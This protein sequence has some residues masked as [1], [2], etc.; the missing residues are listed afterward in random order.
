MLLLLLVVYVQ[1][2]EKIVISATGIAFKTPIPTWFP[3]FI[4]SWALPWGRIKKAEIRWLRGAPQP[5][6]FLVDGVLSRKILL[7]AWVREGEKKPIEKPSLGDIFRYQ[8]MPRA[9]SSEE[10]KTRVEASPLIQALHAHQVPVDYSVKTGTGMMFDLQSHPRTNVATA[11]FLGLLAYAFVDTLYIDEIYIGDY[12]EVIWVGAGLVAAFLTLPLVADP[13]IPRIV[14]AGM[15]AMIGLGVAVALYPGLL[16]LNQLTDSDGL[17]A[18]E[19][20]L[21][22]YVR[23]VSVESGPPEVTFDRYLEYFSQFPLGSPYRLYLRRGGLGFYQLDERPLLEAAR[24]SYEK[25]STE[26]RAGKRR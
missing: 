3:E 10:M 21:H 8:A 7:D 2:R 26:A 18:H 15:A 20:V 19:Y 16:R 9:P 17:V 14:S 1:K 23:L 11:V 12:P 5:A 6:L 22:E 25:K 13:K 24:A 4:S